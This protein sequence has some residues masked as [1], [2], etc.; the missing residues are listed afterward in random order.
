MIYTYPRTRSYRERLFSLPW[1]P[2]Q[3]EVTVTVFD[4]RAPINRER[5]PAIY[6]KETPKP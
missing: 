6:R 2:L 5:V 1:R 3:A 4:P